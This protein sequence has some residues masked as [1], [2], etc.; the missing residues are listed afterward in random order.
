MP[1][2]CGRYTELN[3]LKE[4][5][6]LQ[7]G[8]DFRKPEHRREVFL[9]FYEFHLK[10]RSHPGAVYFLLPYLKEKMSWTDEQSFWFAFLNGNTQNPITSY[11]IFKEFPDL[12]EDFTALEKYF[13]RDGEAYSLL[14]FDTDRRHWKKEFVKSAKCYRENLKGKTQVEYFGDLFSTSDEHENFRR[15]WDECRESFH[16]FGRLSSFSYLEYLRVLGNPLDCDQ[17][18]LD[19]ISGSK[20]HRNGLCKVLGRDDLDDHDSNPDFPGY[21][22]EIISWLVDEAALLLSEAKVRFK[23]ASFERDVS[24]F[25]LESTLCCY[26]S[27]HRPNRRYPNIYMDMNFGR[28]RRAEARWGDKFQIFW[29]ARKDCLPEN[30]RLEDNPFDPGL[31]PE[32]QNHYRLT[33]EVIMM[34]KDWPCFAN[35]F[36]GGSIF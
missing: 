31:V 17:L 20:S 28:I 5:S 27:W 9:R 34:E 15:G 29:D 14:E 11:L 10:Y 22:K 3:G 26:K 30:L 21:S 4:I 35:S 16:G 6:D 8:M 36:R 13:H 18:F 19:D 32:K 1:S 2:K 25:T 33:G 24:Y 23:G 7:V 12:P